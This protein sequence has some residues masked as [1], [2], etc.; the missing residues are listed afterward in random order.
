M[1]K[2]QYFSNYEIEGLISGAWGGGG[3]GGGV[4]L[5]LT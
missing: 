5:K 3:G 4:Q 1:T 2:M